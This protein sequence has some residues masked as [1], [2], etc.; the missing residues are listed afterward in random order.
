MKISIMRI[1][2]VDFTRIIMDNKKEQG[3]WRLANY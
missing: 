1:N 2:D 3:N